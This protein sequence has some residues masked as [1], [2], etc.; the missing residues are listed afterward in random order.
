MPIVVKDFKWRQTVNTVIIQVPLRGIHQSKV[1]IF[2]CNR[3]IRASYSPYF[4]ELFPSQPVDA[5]HSKCTLTA[6]EIVFELF[7]EAPGEWVKLELDI[8]KSE[9]NELKKRLIEEEHAR[10]QK[11][12]ENKSTRKDQLKKT[13]VREQISLDTRQRET[14]ENIKKTEKERA[15]GD[16]DTWKK[17]LVQSNPKIIELNSS[18]SEESDP[19]K[20]STPKSQNFRPRTSRILPKVKYNLKKCDLKD[21]PLPRQTVT[22]TVEFTERELPTPSRESRLEEEQEW[23][24]KQSEVRRA[25]GFVSEDLR[26]EEKDPVYLLAKGNEFLKT[27]NYLGAISAFSF[28][29]KLSEKYPD[30]YRKRSEAHFIIG[31]MQRTIEDCSRALELMKPEVSANFLERV[32][33]IVRRGKALFRFGLREQGFKEIEIAYKMQPDNEELKELLVQFMD[34]LNNSKDKDDD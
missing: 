32:E 8:P 23:L 22:V 25:A 5:A 27:K 21:I 31:N 4:F 19:E 17:D 20:D 26:P 29:I 30:L 18:E 12:C 33:C 7:K 6:S 1:E 2:T 15:L 10:F 3:Y 11:E 28:A 13:S 34:E 9:K 16:I 14:I 24:R